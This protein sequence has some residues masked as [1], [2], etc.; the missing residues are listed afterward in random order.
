MLFSFSQ[1]IAK[2]SI[3]IHNCYGNDQKLI[4]QGRVLDEREFSETKKDD[5]IFTNLWRKLGYIFNDERKNVNLTLEVNSNKFEKKSDDENYFEFDLSFK[6]DSLK[7]NQK[8]NLYL[9]DQK[10][11]NTSCNA[12]ILSNKKQT[13]IISDFDDTIIISDVTNK[14]SLLNQL[15][16]KNYKQREVVKGMKKRFEKILK[17]SPDKALFIITG[18]PKQFNVPI[19]LFLDY[20]NFPKRTIITKKIHGDNSNSLFKQEDYKSQNIETL[21]QLYPNIEWVLFGDSGEKDREIYLDI[22]KKYPS[23]IKEIYIRDV[24]N[25]HIKKIYQK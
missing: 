17:D 25:D 13:G 15:L 1:L 4:L 10:E 20:H 23:H 22:A 14:I 5:N 11:I 18:S 3:Q 6:K 21:L 19:R 2:D 24:K 9:T 16:L 8:I 7:P 12:F